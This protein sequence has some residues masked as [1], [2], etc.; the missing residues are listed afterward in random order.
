M[1]KALQNKIY[2]LAILAIGFGCLLNAVVDFPLEKLDFK[3]LVL[4]CFTI[5]CN[6]FIDDDCRLYDQIFR[7][8]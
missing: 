4:F 5:G 8:V 3:F 1:T 2:M 6:G 7:F